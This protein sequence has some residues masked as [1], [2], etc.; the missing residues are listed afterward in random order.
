MNTE[1]G[2]IRQSRPRR[3][4][5]ARRSSSSR[6]LI[7]AAAAIASAHGHAQQSPIVVTSDQPENDFPAASPSPSPSARPPHRRKSASS[8]RSPPMARERRP[9]PA[10]TA[11]APCTCTFDLTSGQASSSSPARTSPTTGTSPTTAGDRPHDARQALRPRRHP[12]HVQDAPSA[13]TSPSTTTPVHNPTPSP[14]SMRRRRRCRRRR[15]RTTQV[16]FPVKV[17]LYETADE[18]QP[19]IAPGAWA[20]VSHPGRGGLLRYRDGVRRHRHARHHAPRVAHIVTGQATKGPYGIAS[21]LNEGI[22]V[23]SQAAAGGTRTRPSRDPRGQRA[24]VPELSSSAS[25]AVP[26]RSP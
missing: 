1:D 13:R 17:F 4:S 19:A 5:R 16:T 24:L 22:S 3:R 2:S 12:L 23:A 11:S 26:R 9:S 21:W 14:C 8:T 18:M 15:A 7:A 25:V 20:A 6:A 10:V